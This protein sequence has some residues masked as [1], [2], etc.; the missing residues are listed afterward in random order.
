MTNN[1]TF[2]LSA[3]GTIGNITVVNTGNIN[4]SFDVSYSNSR[5]TDYTAFGSALFEEDFNV[6]G[7][8]TNPT[9]LNVTKGE[10][11]TISMYQKGRSTPLDDVGV[12]VVWNDSESRYEYDATGVLD[13]PEK[14]NNCEALILNLES[15]QVPSQDK[16]YFDYIYIEVNYY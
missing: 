4:L 8:I 12:D 2:A 15:V 14:I 11:A 5:T 9:Q 1:N 6:S 3:N 10:N 13:T 7:L 16:V